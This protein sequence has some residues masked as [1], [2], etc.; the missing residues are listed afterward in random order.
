MDINITKKTRLLTKDKVCRENINI[1]PS[2]Q[3]KSVTENGIVVPDSGFVGLNKV[4][5]DVAEIA[6]NVMAS[7]D[8]PKMP[9]LGR[10]K[11]YELGYSKVN[12][13]DVCAINVP[14]ATHGTKIDSNASSSNVSLDEVYKKLFDSFEAM[15]RLI[16]AVQHGDDF[17]YGYSGNSV[18]AMKYQATIGW[19]QLPSI[20]IPAFTCKVAMY[21]DGEI[22]RAEYTFNGTELSTLNSG[23]PGLT[24]AYCGARHRVSIGC[25]L[26]GGLIL[27]AEF[28]YP[29]G[30]VI[31]S[32][33]AT[34]GLQ[35][36]VA[37]TGDFI[38]LK[39][40]ASIKQV[41]HFTLRNTSGNVKGLTDEAGKWYPVL[42]GSLKVIPVTKNTLF[43][44][45]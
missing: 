27:A 45:S 24:E 35:Y 9:K 23:F 40:G 7:I 19:S 42:A 15:P 25:N 38:N 14:N 3:E 17:V 6:G 10:L 4:T 37:D 13:M 28:E 41:E 29:R 32:G 33:S 5:V 44:I 26:N 8:N 16:E 30:D 21:E 22:K 20:I 2:L 18:S 34:D 1:I 31:F 36:R 39:D 11:Y 12:Y 43:K